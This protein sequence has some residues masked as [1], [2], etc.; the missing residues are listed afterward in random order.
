MRPLVVTAPES[1]SSKKRKNKDKESESATELPLRGAPLVRFHQA[2]ALTD[3]QRAFRA[4]VKQ[5]LEQEKIT[6][7]KLAR[8]ADTTAASVCFWLKGGGAEPTNKKIEAAV[9]ELEDE[10]Q[11]RPKKVKVWDR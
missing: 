9:V 2:A 3:E 5:L 10:L 11:K 4:R 7:R 6:Q 8:R 1:T